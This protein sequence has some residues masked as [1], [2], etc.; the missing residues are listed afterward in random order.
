MSSKTSQ[1]SRGKEK[2]KITHKKAIKNVKTK[3][4]IAKESEALIHKL[5]AASRERKIKNA[6]KDSKSIKRY[7]KP[8]EHEM[9]IYKALYATPY[10]DQLR[11]ERELQSFSNQSIKN[12][13][14][15]SK[16]NSSNFIKTLILAP[17]RNIRKR[18]VEN[19]QISVEKDLKTDGDKS[20]KTVHFIHTNSG[21]KSP[22]LK[23]VVNETENTQSSSS[24]LFSKKNSHHFGRSR[25]K[26]INPKNKFVSPSN[27]EVPAKKQNLPSIPNQQKI[28]DPKPVP[29]TLMLFTPTNT[30][31]TIIKS[32]GSEKEQTKT[33][34]RILK[35]EMGGIPGKGTPASND[36]YQAIMKKINEG[37][38]ATMDIPKIKFSCR[39]AFTKKIQFKFIHRA[40]STLEILKARLRVKYNF[41]GHIFYKG[42][43]LV[44]NN[45]KLTEFNLPED[46]EI[47]IVPQ[48]TSG[49]Y[50]RQQYSQMSRKLDQKKQFVKNIKDIVEGLGNIEM[51]DYSLK[52]TIASFETMTES[53]R[54]KFDENMKDKMNKLR[55]KQEKKRANKKSYF[56]KT[57]YDTKKSKKQKSDSS[58]K[59]LKS[60]DSNKNLL[61]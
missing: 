24:S 35:P 27:K 6:E 61:K 53:Q 43:E 29:I 12:S 10:D 58:L 3:K 33:D 19:K 22:A 11:K 5:Q 46:C 16:E 37:K 60:D 31:T 49:D 47:D 8:E 55:L 59:S 44:G 42:K 20:K 1:V 39:N 17:Q 2:F 9:R 14:D 21:Q 38:I 56:S 15:S 26:F 30:P 4:Q 23:E 48:I 54:Q 45:K 36:F 41:I 34:T 57:I 28:E 50:S 18:V 51:E 40:D 13:S 32:N 7:E 52:K 25:R